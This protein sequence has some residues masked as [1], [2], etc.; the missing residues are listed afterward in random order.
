MKTERRHELEVNQLALTM[1][2]LGQQ[3]APYSRLIFGLLALAVV[4]LLAYTQIRANQAAS[5]EAGWQDFFDGVQSPNLDESFS[6]L[7]K[8]HAGEAVA[9]W[10]NLA[11]A[12]DN[13]AQGCESLFR[14]KSDAVAKLKEAIEQYGKLRNHAEPTLASRAIFGAARAEESLGRIDEAKKD[15]EELVKRYP[16]GPFQL[17]AKQ[18]A[19]DLSRA[20]TQKFYDWFS[21][22]TPPSENMKGLPGTPGQGPSLDSSLD[23]PK[24]PITL[25]SLLSKPDRAT[26]GEKGTYRGD[27]GK[28]EE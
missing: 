11:M 19:E 7:V 1:Q 3:I 8:T 24:S 23:A 18:R 12:D 26:E 21:S 4:G 25:D 6:G 2:H 15:Y 10:A 17:Q 27:E 22:Y 13:L 14:N 28:P 5:A 20:P 16:Q 9:D